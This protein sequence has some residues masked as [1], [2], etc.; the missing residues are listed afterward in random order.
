MTCLIHFVRAFV[1]VKSLLE[2]VIISHF[3]HIDVSTINLLTIY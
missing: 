1:N 2:E 3:K